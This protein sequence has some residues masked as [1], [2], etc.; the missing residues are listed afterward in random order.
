V[1][2][3]FLVVAIVLCLG[4]FTKLYVCV[5]DESACHLDRSRWE[6]V[7][8]AAKTAVD[9]EELFKLVDGTTTALEQ[10][11]KT[12]EDK[13]L[14]T[15]YTA[16]K[17]QLE[18]CASA[19]SQM[20]CLS[21]IDSVESNEK[22]N[23]LSSAMT[24]LSDFLEG[25]EDDPFKSYSDWLETQWQEDTEDFAVEGHL[26]FYDKL[27]ITGKVLRNITYDPWQDMINSQSQITIAYYQALAVFVGSCFSFT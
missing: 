7:I 19:P 21:K 4:G 22:K 20:L 17:L 25:S 3:R 15:P 9:Q 27:L 6:A 11:F 14:E 16:L 18:N 10:L 1:S 26:E 23:K 5:S 13:A 24:D 2:R 8:T 12:L